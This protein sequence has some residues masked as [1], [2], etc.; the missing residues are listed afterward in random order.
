MGMQTSSEGSFMCKSFGA[1]VTCVIS[2]VVV[3]V[4]ILWNYSF[5][6]V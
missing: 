6:A 2:Q 3:A 5:A 4:G 1:K